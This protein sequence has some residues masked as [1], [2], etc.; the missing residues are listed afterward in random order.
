MLKIAVC[1][2]DIKIAEYI[3]KKICSRFPENSVEVFSS[4]TSLTKYLSQA[5]NEVDLLF[6]DIVLKDE[7]GIDL[8]AQIIKKYPH[9]L[10]VFITA[11][12]NEFSERIFLK[13][14]PYG[15]LHKPIKDELLFHYVDSAKQEIMLQNR[16]LT[17]K[18]GVSTFEIPFKKI[19]C[20]ESEK[21][22]LHIRCD[23]KDY[24]VYA[25]LDDV[26]KSLDERFIRCHKS[27]LV[28]ADFVKSFEKDSFILKGEKNI[29]I[30]KAMHSQA[31]TNYFKAKGRKLK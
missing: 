4:S 31:K 21:R 2:D 15:Y 13:L 24:D 29:P 7:D 10:T 22:I 27:Y 1:D 20:I 14:K 18:I 30:S 11:Y 8:A 9:I 3:A 25:K 19:M 26:Q 5:G 6:M 23:D 12:I 28:N 16:S 17:V